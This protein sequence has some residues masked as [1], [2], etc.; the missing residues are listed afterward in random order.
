[1]KKYVLNAIIG[2]GFG[3]PITLL[4]MTL[5]GGYHT[6]IKELLIW[7]AASALYGLLSTA[8]DDMSFDMPLPVS[9]GIHFFGCI[10]I[11]MGAVL[12]CG[13]VSSVADLIPIM[14]P[15]VGIYV[16]V[17]FICFLLMKQ[18]EKAVN[19]ALEEK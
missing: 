10:A 15:A 3:F 1:M 5:M 4:C 12:L 16:I 9:I 2:M 14:I 6:V 17:H 7:M 11:T 18:N 8:M 19:K 13:Y